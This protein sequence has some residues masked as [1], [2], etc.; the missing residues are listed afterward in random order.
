MADSRSAGGRDTGLVLF[1]REAHGIRPTAAAHRLV[2]LS[3]RALAPLDDLDQQVREP[4]T[5]VTGRLR[6]G[7]F[8]TA[9]DRL[10]RHPLLREDLVLLRS[11]DSRLGASLPQLAEARWITGAEGTAEA[12]SLV[13]LC[14][15]AGFDAEVA[16]R[17]NAYDVARELVSTGLGVAGV[18]ALGHAPSEAIRATRLTQRH[19]RVGGRSAGRV[20]GAGAGRRRGRPARRRAPQGPGTGVGRHGGGEWPRRPKAPPA[21]GPRR[22]QDGPRPPGHRPSRRCPPRGEQGR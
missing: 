12:L 9:S 19:G 11:A 3:G 17:S 2:D 18:P 7:S 15:A 5:G 10:T 20:P 13:R 1:E 21:P 8:P 16:F 4:A 14:A 6:L 22:R